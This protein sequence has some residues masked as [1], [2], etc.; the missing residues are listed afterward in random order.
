MFGKTTLSL[1]PMDG[2]AVPQ[3]LVPISASPRT[4]A[5]E[6]VLRSPEE[7]LD[8]L[9][10]RDLD[11]ILDLDETLYLRN[12]TEDFIDGAW[13]GVLA[14]LVLRALDLLKPWRWTGGV[15]TRDCWR[16]G[17]VRLLFPWTL[18]RWRRR[19]AQLASAHINTPLLSAAQTHGRV[20][21]I[22][23][24]GFEGIV[25]PLVHAMGLPEATCVASRTWHFKDRSQGKL[26]RAR[27]V[28]D[29]GS[30]ERSIVVTDSRDDHDLL[31][32]CRVPVLVKW[33]SA[34]F[35]P[36]LRRVYLPGQYL[37]QVKRP[38]ERYILRGIL[39]EDFAFWLLAALFVS[40]VPVWQAA[41]A[42]GLLL[43]S[44]WCIYERGYVDNDLAAARFE[45]DPKLSAAFR[46]APV[47]T[48]MWTP[49]VWAFGSAAAALCVLRYPAWPTIVDGASWAAVLV[50]TYAWFWYYNR[51]DKRSRVWM[52]GGLQLARTAAFV[53]LLPV[54]PAGAMAL[55][56]H[57]IARWIPYY[58]Y[59]YGSKEWPE[60]PL[61]LTRLL[62]FILLCGLMAA[63]ESPAGVYDLSFGALLLWNIYRARQDLA[64]TLQSVRRID[65]G[66]RRA[67]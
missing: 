29:A 53:V 24:A 3:E 56:A 64:Q 62:F 34:R 19:V 12:S 10:L 58:M 47:A 51:I 59:R 17:L 16:V 66:S 23:T 45:A 1:S 44:F 2:A 20:P 15:S 61:C 22:V 25:E 5:E 54:S 6:L 49:W 60:A 27:S 37:S 39:Q 8:C 11:L 36:G 65:R 41:S 28:L 33:P 13:P 26:A 43:L 46:E 18:W 63:V 32:A 14:L 48:P 35:E 9:R 4:G 67:P 55:A 57:V 50:G 30:V 52:F 21:T 38:G 31:R 7:A 40:P 42:L